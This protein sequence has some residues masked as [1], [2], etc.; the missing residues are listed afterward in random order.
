M[1]KIH[2]LYLLLVFTFNACSDLD[3]NPI[4]EFKEN[5][6]IDKIKGRIPNLS[7]NKNANN[8]SRSKLSFKEEKDLALQINEYINQ[9]YE[10]IEIPMGNYKIYRTIRLKSDVKLSFDYDA[11]IRR[12]PSFKGAIIGNANTN[13][14]IKNVEISGG[15]FYSNE[16][17]GNIIKLKCNNSIFENIIVE[18]FRAIAFHLKGNNNLLQNL[19]VYGP[20]KKIGNKDWNGTGAIHVYQG[21]HNTIKNL[22]LNSGDDGVAFQPEGNETISNSSVYNCTIN[23]IEGASCVAGLPTESKGIVRDIIFN[24]IVGVVKDNALIAIVN[25]SKR[26]IF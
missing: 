3:N 19:E 7:Y 17:N 1:R 10:E 18:N 12:D 16:N 5:I 11:I 15:I 20:T 21:K 6:A 24:D 4:E 23:S 13:S 8:K 22:I 2:L 9:G 25:K 26:Q 14:Y